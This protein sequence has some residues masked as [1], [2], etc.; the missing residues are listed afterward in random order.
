[1]T[2]WKSKSC[3]SDTRLKFLWMRWGVCSHRGWLILWASLASHPCSSDFSISFWSSDLKPSPSE[4]L[5][6]GE[7]PYPVWIKRVGCT[8]IWNL[9]G[10]SLGLSWTLPR[11][12]W[13]CLVFQGNVLLNLGSQM[14]NQP[15]IT[16]NYLP[17]FSEESLFPL[18]H[19]EQHIP[20]AWILVVL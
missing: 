9:H 4:G 12:E 18:L 10:L 7:Y 8:C 13:L 2:K 11:L 5:E 3:Y 14:R 19:A 6:W 1:M 17:P 15:L 20:R 16:A